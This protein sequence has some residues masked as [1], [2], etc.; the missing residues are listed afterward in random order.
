[1]EII[2]SLALIFLVFSHFGLRKKVKNLEARMA[3]LRGAEPQVAGTDDAPVS[4]Q[5]AATTPTAAA[6]AEGA[7][8]W[9]KSAVKDAEDE[10]VN[11]ELP[12]REII[13][14]TPPKA[15]VLKPEN[16]AKAGKWLAQNWF[17]AVAALSL[18]LAGVFMVQYGVEQGLITPF[19]RVMGAAFLGIALIGAGEFV[20]RRWGDGDQSHTAYLPSTFAGAGLVALFAAVLAARQM[21]GLIGSE[22]ALIY[23]VMVSIVAIVLGWYY[24]PYLAVVGI[25]GSLAAPFLVGGESSAPQ[26]FF[27]YFAIVVVAALAVDTVKRW[28]WVSVLA[29]VFGYIAAFVI[30]DKSAG[31]EHFLAFALITAVA[32]VT[33]PQRSLWPSH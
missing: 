12:P 19:W 2:L 21:Y 9:E 14:D 27:Y 24:G 13:D 22:T 29:L 8:P 30:F 23:L 31:D 6:E 32:S 25:L 11:I 1:M 33:I 26:L 16:I 4:D 20:R 10:T 5:I 17:L 3:A 28:A 18:A 7:G 15:F